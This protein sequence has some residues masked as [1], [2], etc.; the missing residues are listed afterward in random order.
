MSSGV[1]YSLEGA[2][3]QS[4][5]YVRLEMMVLSSDGSFLPATVSTVLIT[6]LQMISTLPVTLPIGAIPEQ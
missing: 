6:T 1:S 4:Q 3:R 5:K 2:V